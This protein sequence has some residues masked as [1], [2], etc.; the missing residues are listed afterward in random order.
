MTF[1]YSGTAITTDIE[2]I[3]LELGDTIEAEALYTDEELQVFLDREGDVIG[4]ATAA[5][6]ALV[7][8][9]ARAYD[10]ETDGQRFSRSQMHKQFLATLSELTSRADRTVTTTPTTRVDGYSDNVAFDEVDPLR[11]SLVRRDDDWPL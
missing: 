1:S 6:G 10:F 2:R 4:A 7:R 11:V 8:R 5:C 3:R 9:F